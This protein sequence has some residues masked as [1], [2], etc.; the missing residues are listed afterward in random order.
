MGGG[1]GGGVLLHICLPSIQRDTNFVFLRASVSNKTL[2]RWDL[3][4]KERGI[5][6]CS[7][8]RQNVNGRVASTENMLSVAFNL[9]VSLWFCTNSRQ[10]PMLLE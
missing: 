5:S 8:G 6:P 2:P 3:L 4:L 7:E 9:A 10:D 1:G